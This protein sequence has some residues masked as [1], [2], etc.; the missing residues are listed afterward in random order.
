MKKSGFVG[1]VAA[2]GGSGRSARRVVAGT[3]VGFVGIGRH[4]VRCVTEGFA[5]LRRLH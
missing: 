5:D 3:D 4:C 2:V 1:G